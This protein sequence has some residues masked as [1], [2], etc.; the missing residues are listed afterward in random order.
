MF[1][2]KFP[3]IIF[4]LIIILT[5]PT[6]AQPFRTPSFVEGEELRYKVTFYQKTSSPFN[7]PH[8]LEI[9]NKIHRTTDEKKRRIIKHTSTEHRSDKTTAMWVF[10]YSDTVPTLKCLNFSR[11][12]CSPLNEEF[13][14]EYADLENPFLIFPE[15]VAHAGAIPFLMSAI[16]WEEEKMMDAYV[17]A[18]DGKPTH[19]FVLYSGEDEIKVPA[20]H[21][22]AWRVITKVD[23]KEVIEPW[24][25]F[26]NLI[27]RLI[28]EFVFWYDCEPPHRLLKIKVDFG[29]TSAGAPVMYQE[30]YSIKH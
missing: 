26:G 19:I 13:F 12:I 5:V 18:Q 20:G 11:K 4:A 16:P 25:V 6:Q 1:S 8:P 22:K 9:I 14:Y 27:A 28:P 15:N 29:V 30:L 7:T 10:N 21:F 2:S 17:W 24:G 23:K 3:I